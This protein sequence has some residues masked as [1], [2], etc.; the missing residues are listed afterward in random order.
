MIGVD[1]NEDVRKSKLSAA[2]EKIGMV[3][4]ITQQHGQE[5]PPTYE[6]GSIPIDG[7]YVSQTLMG[8]KCGYESFVGTIACFGLRYHFQWHLVTIFLT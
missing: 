5:G 8:A 7:I 6:R 4:V 1:A 2:L 3:K